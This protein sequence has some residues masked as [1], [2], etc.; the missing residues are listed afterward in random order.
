[1]RIQ[2]ELPV[3]EDL[4]EQEREAFASLFSASPDECCESCGTRLEVVDYSYTLTPGVRVPELIEYCP[5]CDGD[6][7]HAR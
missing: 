2:L 7:H 6:A 5:K 1:M 4:I 3:V